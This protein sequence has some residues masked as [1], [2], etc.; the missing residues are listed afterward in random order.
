MILKLML[1]F[2]SL[3]MVYFGIFHWPWDEKEDPNIIDAEFEEKP[4]EQE[5]KGIDVFI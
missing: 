5:Y 3:S 2:T 1:L 4:D